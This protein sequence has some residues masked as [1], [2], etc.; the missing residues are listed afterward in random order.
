MSGMME[1]IGEMEEQQTEHEPD[2]RLRASGGDL[3]DEDP[4]TKLARA[5]GQAIRAHE[6]PIEDDGEVEPPP[7]Q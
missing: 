2:G 3:Y 5:V 7:A 4:H 1:T 6:G